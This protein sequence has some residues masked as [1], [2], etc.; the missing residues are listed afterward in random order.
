MHDSRLPKFTRRSFLTLA[1][2]AVLA[3]T[4]AK[5]L[6]ADSDKL[7][8]R[9]AVP[10]TAR[11]KILLQSSDRFVKQVSLLTESRLAVSMHAAG[12]LTGPGE[13]LDAV[14]SGEADCG[15]IFAYEMAQ[16]SLAAEW[17]FSVP[18]GLSPDGLNHWFYAG[19]GLPLLNE[20]SRDLGIVALP[21]GDTGPRPT[22]WFTKPLTTDMSSHVAAM[23]GRLATAVLKSA[24]MHTKTFSLSQGPEDLY[25]DEL[26]GLGS[27]GAYLDMAARFNASAKRLYLPCDLTP[28]GRMLFIANRKTYDSLPAILRKLLQTACAQEDIRLQADMAYAESEARHR[29]SLGEGSTVESVPEKVVEMFKSHASKALDKVAEGD[30]MATKVHGKYKK[31]L[32]E[33]HRLVESSS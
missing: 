15:H 27:H 21:M 32:A 11:E 6:M 28:S 22:G 19:E 26:T 20:L 1:G 5:P 4:M 33:M 29:A 31:Y 13:V 30:G 7:H 24:G 17:F 8:W 23:P 25:R 9:M 16:E 14:R 3:G 12:T 2:T 10:W 18:F